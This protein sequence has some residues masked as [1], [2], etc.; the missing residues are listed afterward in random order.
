MR[1]ADGRK[2]E[3][4]PETLKTT[5]RKATTLRMSR[6]PRDRGVCMWTSLVR[7]HSVSK[8]AG[9]DGPDLAL[10]DRPVMDLPNRSAHPRPA[11]LAMRSHRRP[12]VRS[13]PSLL[14]VPDPRYRTSLGSVAASAA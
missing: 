1:S 13:N 3:P 8:A 11:V 6:A 10:A 2:A 9:H 14:Q 4:R 5:T 7:H 12:R